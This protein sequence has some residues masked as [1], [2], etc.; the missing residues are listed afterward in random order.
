MPVKNKTLTVYPEPNDLAIVGGNSPACNRAIACW[1]RVLRRSMPVL[2]RAEWNFL[3]D[4]LNGDFEGDYVLA[5][6]EHGASALA[7]EV[8]DAQGLDGTGDK[9]FGEELSRGSG[10]IGADEL[11]AKVAALT[12][13]QIQYVR[14]AAAFFWSSPAIHRI[15]HEVDD[16]WTIEFRARLLRVAAE[17]TE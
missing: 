15:D 14:T 12:W 3:A 1:A 17:P 6:F 2:S 7:L 16:W 8:H 9:W 5:L 13:E 4:V 11:E 10:Q